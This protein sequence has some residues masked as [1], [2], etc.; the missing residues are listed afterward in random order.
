MG[1]AVY[2]D[3]A[4]KAFG[5]TVDRPVFLRPEVRH[6]R[7]HGRQH[8]AAKPKIADDAP[9]FDHCFGGFLEVE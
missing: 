2:G 6:V 5:L 9:Q 3:G 8:R 7:A 4:A 1:A